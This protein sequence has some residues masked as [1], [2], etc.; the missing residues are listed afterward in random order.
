MNVQFKN[1]F[2]LPVL[3]L[4]LLF[5]SGC[6]KKESEPAYSFEVISSGAGFF[7]Y[8]KIDGGAVIDFLSHPMGTTGN[9]FNFE[10][11]M[12]SPKS[13]VVSATGGVGTTSITIYIY[14][15]SE[16]VDSKTTVTDGTTPPTVTIT[17]TFDSE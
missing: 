3:I 11:G 7:G 6:E 2:F 8:Y 10:K 1:I 13:I 15:N 5:L 14:A 17:H 16:P 4:S 9:Y 12:N